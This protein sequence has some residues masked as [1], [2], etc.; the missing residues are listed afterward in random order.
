MTNIIKVLE[1]LIEA[2]EPFTSDEVVDETT[3]TIPLMERLE[4]AIEQAE[5]ILNKY[6]GY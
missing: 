4:E 6:K 3:G 2:A 1:E 5:N